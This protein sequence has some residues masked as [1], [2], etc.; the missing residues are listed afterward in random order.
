MSLYYVQKLLYELNRDEDLQTQFFAD[1]DSV[2]ADYK[3]TEE[4]RLALTTPDIGLLYILG[5][6][7]QILM[8]YA[9]MCGYAWPEYIQ[10]MRDAL[11][12]YGNVRAGLYVTTDGK[13]AV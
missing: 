11:E 5:V 10:A 3:L 9:A 1:K 4:E 2:L 12:K 13:G 6:N 8:H 7:G